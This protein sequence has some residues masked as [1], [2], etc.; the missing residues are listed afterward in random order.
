[1][2]SL[3][4]ISFLVRFAGLLLVAVVGM[5]AVLSYLFARAH[6]DALRS[7]LVA[8]AAGQASATLQPAL[9]K[10]ARS[11]TFTE[12]DRAGVDAAV[13]NVQNFQSLV[14]T[15]WLY[16]PDG[17]PLDPIVAP[18]VSAMV[19]R[20][21]AE[22]NIIQG[23]PKTNGGESVIPVYVPL[24]SS[25]GNGYLAVAEID[26]SAG[27][28][29]AQ[30]GSETR[31]VITA[32]I[33]GCSLIFL[34]LLT[35]AVAAQR[36]L[37]LRRRQAETT[38]LQTMEGLAAIVDQRDPYTAG[39]SRRVSEYSVT[40]AR[41]LGLREREVERVRWSA[42][43]HDLGKI[44]IPDRVL[45]KD[46]PLDPEE[47]AIISQHP[48]IAKEILAPVEA[49]A[50]IVPC[51]LHHHERWDGRGYPAGLSGEAIPLLARIIAVADTFDAMT[52]DRPYRR[53]LEI[54]EARTRL[55]EGAGSQWDV[56]CI[57]AAVALIDAGALRKPHAVA[58][59]F[60]PRL[61]LL[62]PTASRT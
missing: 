49:M 8:N 48:T 1:V 50:H 18:D 16:R 33:V 56:R 27:Q 7:D 32:T 39:H 46:G 28:L 57:D 14:G 51:V 58:A 40:I 3:G 13:R 12:T 43:L 31:F 53:G 42:L 54:T 41:H 25:T 55:R 9:E 4:K 44:G 38:F 10:Y 17:S 29:D 6:L 21:I 30:T 59:E 26:V 22:Q 52:T 15:V 23:A 20:A 60:G 5:S 36:E 37:N 35:L 11:G 2:N 24:A 62:R 19:K 45:L 61:G 34:S 47:R